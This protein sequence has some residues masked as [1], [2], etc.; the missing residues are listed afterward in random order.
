MEREREHRRR[1]R[2]ESATA[3]AT[4]A[5]SATLWGAPVRS[6][7][8]RTRCSVV[9]SAPMSRRQGWS[10]R[11][12]SFTRRDATRSKSSSTTSATSTKSAVRKTNARPYRNSASRPINRIASHRIASTMNMHIR[13]TKYSLLCLSLSPPFPFCF[14]LVQSVCVVDIYLTEFSCVL[15]LFDILLCVHQQATKTKIEV[16]H[17]TTVQ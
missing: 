6:T 8:R 4:S 9:T 1:R 13:C 14:S 7:R 2:T 16:F 15:M 3:A 5:S 10:Q 11:T 17:Q 12:A